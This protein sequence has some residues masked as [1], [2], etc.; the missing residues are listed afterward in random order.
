M[1]KSKFNT[2]S[3]LLVPVLWIVLV[4][5]LSFICFHLGRLTAPRHTELRVNDCLIPKE[6]EGEELPLEDS[7]IEVPEPEEDEVVID[8]QP[9]PDP[10]TI[11]VFD[12]R[13]YKITAY[14]PSKDETQGD[15]CISSIGVNLCATS[16]S[17]ACPNSI[18]NNY[19]YGTRIGIG[20][21]D[22]YCRDHAPY[23][24]IDIFMPTKQEAIEFDFRW[25]KV[26]IYK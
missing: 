21:K 17:V 7:S 20:E 5:A 19:G 22:Y 12:E 18:I 6:E 2:I 23:N 14:S 10:T 26:R 16:D 1:P 4:V 3:R 11:P 25:E 15:P 8:P 24:V 9:E 13:T